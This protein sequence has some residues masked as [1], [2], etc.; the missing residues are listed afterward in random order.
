[1][2]TCRVLSDHKESNT[3]RSSTILLRVNLGL[4]KTQSVISFDS[5]VMRRTVRNGRYQSID[6]DGSGKDHLRRHGLLTHK[7]ARKM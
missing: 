6:R 4:Y 7:V 5:G 3:I 2:G 1:M